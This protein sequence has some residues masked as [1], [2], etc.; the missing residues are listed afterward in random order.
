M[1]K[2]QGCDQRLNHHWNDV[3]PPV[4]LQPVMREGSIQRSEQSCFQKLVYVA[5]LKV[6][7]HVWKLPAEIAYCRWHDGIEVG[8]ACKAKVQLAKLSTC[9]PPCGNCRLFRGGKSAA[10][11]YQKSLAGF[12]EFC[13]VGNSSQQHGA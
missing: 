1:G 12:G 6:Q 7:R 3:E 5:L 10:A 2:G 11:F 9:R 8:R 13:T 4:L